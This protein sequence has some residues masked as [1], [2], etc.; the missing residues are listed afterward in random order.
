MM[1]SSS[2]AARLRRTILV[3]LLG[4]HM[5]VAC[6]KG[7]KVA[8]SIHGV[9]Y[10]GDEFSYIVED[11]ANSKNS[12]GGETIAPL[13]QAAPCAVMSCPENGDRAFRLGFKSRVGCRRN[14]TA[15]CRK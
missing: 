15:V 8:A 4:A 9:N 14:W 12:G 10:S 13:A 1:K 6:A 3:A 5:L 7:N 11:P 2:P